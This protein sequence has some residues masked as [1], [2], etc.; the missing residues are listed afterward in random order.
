LD[1]ARQQLNE[2]LEH[3][4]ATSEVL[5]VISSSPG[6]LQSVFQ[7]MLVNA[8]RLCEA[9]FGLL[10]LC[11]GDGFRT[12]ALHNVPPALAEQRQRDG[13]IRPGPRTGLG[14]VASTKEVVYI[15]D[16]AVEPAY[17]E[18]D[19]LMVTLAELGGGRTLLVVPKDT[20]IPRAVQTVG[21]TLAVPILGGLHH[22]YIRA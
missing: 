20:P 13:V 4:T 18:R 16:A 2:A 6:E 19:P 8:T 5:G 9:K 11:E 10:L 1:G 14:R 22:H 15:T 21:R 17:I 12:V 3:Q 7:A